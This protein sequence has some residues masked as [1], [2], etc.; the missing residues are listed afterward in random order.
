MW[1][2]VDN[3]LSMRSHVAKPHPPPVENECG[4]MCTEHRGE[5]ATSTGSLLEF[6]TENRREFTPTRAKKRAARQTNSGNPYSRLSRRSSCR[7]SA[8]YPHPR[9]DRLLI[10][11]LLRKSLGDVSVCSPVPDIQAGRSA[12]RATRPM[13]P[14]SRIK[15]T[16]MCRGPKFARG[17]SAMRKTN[18]ERRSADTTMERLSAYL[19]ELEAALVARNSLRVTAL[20]R[21]RVAAHIPREVREE[22]MVLSRLPRNSHRAPIQF[23]RFEHRISELSRGGERLPTAQLELRLDARAS[24]AVRRRTRSAAA[25]DPDQ[26]TR[27]D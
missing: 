23:Y 6:S 11:P 18:L 24:G 27:K 12:M 7:E 10:A 5:S 8:A 16:Q 26:R 15:R 14:S 17:T 3:A 4:Q 13:S 19:D 20:L 1:R 25:R 22:L 9:V 2:V 21:R